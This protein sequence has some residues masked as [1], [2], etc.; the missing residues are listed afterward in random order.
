MGKV[1]IGADHRGYK[2]KDKIIEMLRESGYTV[3]DIGAKKYDP[4]DDYI[5]FA[6]K[7]AEEVSLQNI[8]GIIICRSGIG[9]SIAANKV[10]GIRAGLCTTL[11]QTRLARTDDDINI[12]CLS[13]ELV[14]EEKN[15][16]IVKKF[17]ETV[18]SSDER[19][20]NRIIKIKK[21]EVEKC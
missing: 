21:Y 13:A 15:F 7:V 12:L 8:K 18:F 4:D 11:K 20:I 14:S 19:Y 17:L 6:V 5:D 10:D 16:K 2:L 9:V 3:T 1:I